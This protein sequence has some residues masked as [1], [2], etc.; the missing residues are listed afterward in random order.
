MSENLSLTEGRF[1]RFEKIEWWDQNLLAQSKILVIGAGA[2]GNE[3]IK[4]L[5]LLGVGHIA[6]ADMD[7]IEESNLTRSVLFRQ[8]NTGSYKANCAASMAKEIYPKINTYPLVIN[9]LSEMG[10]GWFNWADVVIG[11]LDNREARV[12]VNQSCMLTNK[13]WF[14]GGIDVLNG[15]V[16]GFSSDKGACYECT[17][18]SVDWQELAQRRSCA[19]VLKRSEL[20]NGAPTTPTTASVI[21]AMQCQEV[22]KFLHDM[23]SM[24]GNGWFFDGLNH[25][26]YKVE[27]PINPECMNHEDKAKIEIHEE[28]NSETLLSE[29]WKLAEKNIVNLQA[30]DFSRELVNALTCSNCNF[31]KLML[32]PLE[33]IQPT[34]VY[35][36]S[37]S[38][39]LTPSFIHSITKDHPLINKT[40]REIGLPTWDIVWVR[41]SELCIGFEISGDIPLTIEKK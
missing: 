7:I 22:I 23:P 2:L 16:R 35:C 41:N 33:A 36:E 25:D 13:T 17:M 29:L 31:E 10:L 40:I 26:S 19:M 32:K 18:S 11:G 4:N 9:I 15:I 14:D 12:F 21:A 8:N 20:N 28:L 39:E 24:I 37:C 5:A 27:Y 34:D 6:I 1:A 30:I 3:I 38:T